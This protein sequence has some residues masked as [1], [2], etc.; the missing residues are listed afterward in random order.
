M[1]FVGR[2]AI[3][4]VAAVLVLWGSQ[5]FVYEPHACNRM[6][7]DLTRRTSLAYDT[8][9]DFT[10]IDR[11]RRNLQELGALRERCPT[12]VRGY[13]LIGAN[14]EILGR[15]DDAIRSY[16]QSLAIEQRPEI[17]AAIGDALIQTG[18]VDEAVES[19]FTAVRF[20]P[21][22]MQNIQSELVAE[23]VAARLRAQR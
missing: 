12:D 21:G 19:Y 14:E 9:R 23:R 13:M 1:R 11:A 18:R 15:H 3:V 16:R 8:G 2:L 17:H 22:V 10:R 4:I 6:V 7:T 5:R 20:N